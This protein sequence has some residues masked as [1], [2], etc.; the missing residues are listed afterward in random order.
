M[1]TMWVMASAPLIW[2]GIGIIVDV[3]VA[4]VIIII[5]VIVVVIITRVIIILTACTQGP[6]LARMLPHWRCSRG[7]KCST[8]RRYH[9]QYQSLVIIIILASHISD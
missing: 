8:C 6:P 5:I 9:H 1:M 7:A 2:G 4:V 3:I